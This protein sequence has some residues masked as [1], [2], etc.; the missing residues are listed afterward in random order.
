MSIQTQHPAFPGATTP[1]DA[2]LG[3]LKAGR[4]LADEGVHQE[5]KA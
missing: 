3:N 1:G 2:V 5:R 4:K